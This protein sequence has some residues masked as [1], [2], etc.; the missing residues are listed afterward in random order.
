MQFRFQFSFPRNA[1]IKG[2]NPEFTPPFFPFSKMGTGEVV[3]VVILIY[4]IH[5]I[6]TYLFFC[7]SSFFIKK[8]FPKGYKHPFRTIAINRAEGSDLAK[9][10]APPPRKIRIFINPLIRFPSHS[11]RSPKQTLLKGIPESLWRRKKHDIVLYLQHEEGCIRGSVTFLCRPCS[12]AVSTSSSASRGWWWKER[13]WIR[14]KG[15]ENL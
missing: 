9:N 7:S 14:R 1:Q 2:L 12:P 6:C 5:A 10:H 15:L 4:I 11:L 8:M 3:F 13:G